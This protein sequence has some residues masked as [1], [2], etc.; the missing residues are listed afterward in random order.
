[1]RDS[2]PMHFL[3]SGRK[4]FQVIINKNKNPNESNEYTLLFTGMTAGKILSIL[5]ALEAVKDEVHNPVAFDVLRAMEDRIH[6]AHDPMLSD[7]EVAPGLRFGF[8]GDPMFKDDP[9]RGGSLPH[10][11][12]SHQP[13][14][15]PS[16]TAPRSTD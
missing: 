6:A 13:E 2:N 12:K 7:I 11:H 5:H 3:K 8:G 15:E 16:S 9:M 4:P 14:P 1:M 10:G